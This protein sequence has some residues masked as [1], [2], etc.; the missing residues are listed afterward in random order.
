MTF[1]VGVRLY[2]ADIAC[3]RAILLYCR[4]CSSY[5]RRAGG[6]NLAF[7]LGILIGGFSGRAR[8]GQS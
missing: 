8:L 5:W 7:T 4:S 2:R 1:A 6:W 3:S